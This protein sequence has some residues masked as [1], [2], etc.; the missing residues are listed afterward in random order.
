MNL[1][2]HRLILAAGSVNVLPI[3]G[4][5]TGSQAAQNA[6]ALEFAL[7]GAELDALSRSTA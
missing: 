3:P 1:D 4:A 6:G 2:Y 7:S 5:K